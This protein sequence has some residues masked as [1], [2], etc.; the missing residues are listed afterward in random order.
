VLVIEYQTGGYP[1]GFSE[2]VLTYTEM[3]Y[4]PR[5]MDAFLFGVRDEQ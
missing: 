3:S 1:T 4:L 2:N 5:R